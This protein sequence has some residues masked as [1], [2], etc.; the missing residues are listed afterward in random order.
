M[1]WFDHCRD[2]YD[3]LG[4]ALSTVVSPVG[5]LRG[6]PG[7]VLCSVAGTSAL[8]VVAVVVVAAP[9]A[10]GMA[11]VAGEKAAVQGL[12][13]EVREGGSDRRCGIH[14]FPLGGASHR[15]GRWD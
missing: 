4:L 5:I 6:A 9:S 1:V 2:C 14:L 8:Q 7:L 15:V 10:Y 11:W 12:S 13:Y 3:D